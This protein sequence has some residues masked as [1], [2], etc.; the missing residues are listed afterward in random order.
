VGLSLAAMAL[1]NVVIDTVPVGNPGNAVDTRYPDTGDGVSSFGSVGYSYNIGKYEVTAGQYTAFLNAVA[2]IDTYG[3]YNPYMWSHTWGCKIQR[4]GG[5]TVGNPY[6][7]AVFDDPNV[8][9]TEWA[10]RPVN[11]VSWG[12]SARFANWLH[13][14]QPTGAQ[15][16]STTEDGSYYLNGATSDTALLAVT[17]KANATWVMSSEDEWYKAA[18]HKNDGVT[19]NYFDYPTSSNIAPS[20]V[21]GNPADPG[22]IATYYDYY[23]TGNGG[24]TIGSP[25]W[26]T[27]VGA[28]ENSD[29][30][31]GTFDQ[32]GNVWEWNE[33]ALYGSYRSLRGGS[34]GD[35][36]DLLRAAGRGGDYPSVEFSFFGFRVVEVP[37][38]AALSLLALVGVMVLRRTKR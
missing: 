20:N 11:W 14:G 26:R 3:L 12:D 28:H 16:A 29:S 34:F 18:Y 21:L 24:Y 36:A 10:N 38:P 23:G 1:A 5:G 32:G 35:H 7:Y 4:S 6:T 30:P 37:E 25:Y 15:N 27:E 22:N 31:Y 9:G 13:N 33:A 19:G 2:R 17:R 8:P